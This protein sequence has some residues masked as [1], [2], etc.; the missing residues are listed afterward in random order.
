VLDLLARLRDRVAQPAVLLERD[1]A[2]P[3]DAALAAELAAIRAVAESP[4][5]GGPGRCRPARVPTGPDPTG[6]RERLGTAQAGLIRALVAGGDPTGFDVERIHVQA[7]ALVAKR[8][9]VVARLRPDLAAEPGF[10]AAFAAWA[11]T[12]PPTGARADAAAFGA[13]TRPANASIER[14]GSVRSRP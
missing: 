8:R 13:T 2:Y 3:S 9:D 7:D 10:R 5:P 14:P 12:R 11:R 4:G 6:A 1:G